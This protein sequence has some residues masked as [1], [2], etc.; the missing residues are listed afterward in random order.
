MRATQQIIRPS[1]FATVRIVRDPRDASLDFK[2]SRAIAE[3]LFRAGALAW[4]IAEGAY[5]SHGL[6]ARQ[7]LAQGAAK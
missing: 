3:S 2:M 4:D 5:A 1:A 7:L 6:S